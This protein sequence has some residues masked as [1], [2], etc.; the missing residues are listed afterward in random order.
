MRFDLA[1]GE[2]G[3]GHEILRVSWREIAGE[4]PERVP[5][6]RARKGIDVAPS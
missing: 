6:A 4:R 5:V 3:I 1:K 2:E